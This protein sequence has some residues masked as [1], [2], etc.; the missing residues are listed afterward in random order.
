MELHTLSAAEIV[1]GVTGGEFS[2]S[3]VFSACMA[4][5]EEGE[6]SLSALLAVTEEMGRRTALRVDALIARGENPGPLAGVPVVL[7]DNM[8]LRGVP[9]TCAS[10][11]LEGWIPPYDA[12]VAELLAEAGAVFAGKT[13]MDEFAM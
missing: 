11:I 9:T 2:A 10:R 13:N 12:A 1:R 7:K 3:E 6:P 4:R 8:C 5:I